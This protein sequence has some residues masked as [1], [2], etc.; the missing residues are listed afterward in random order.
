MAL[1]SADST[2]RDA[3]NRT[4]ESFFRGGCIF[5]PA[6][7]LN[8]R[9]PLRHQWLTIMNTTTLIV[10]AGVSFMLAGG[11][12][13]AQSFKPAST[14]TTITELEVNLMRKDLRDQKKQLVAANLPLNGDEAAAF[15]PLYDSYTQETIK[16]N[17]QRY[18]LVKQ[19]AA[20]YN[21]MTDEQAST[22]S[23]SGSRW[24]A[25]Q[26]SCDWIGS[27]NSKRRSA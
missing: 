14:G 26:R 12:A 1:V 11:C 22:I 21:T 5:T 16:I 10:I 15:W 17:D 13:Q 4:R 23:A 8:S 3:R 19:Y 7:F 20:N 6:H 25:R 2:R 9:L 27:R 24:T 18:A